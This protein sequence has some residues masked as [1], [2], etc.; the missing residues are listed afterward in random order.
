[1]GFLLGKRA[2][3][4][5]WPRYRSILPKTLKYLMGS[6]PEHQR[7]ACTTANSL[8]AGE[9]DEFNR[10]LEESMVSSK[11]GN[12]RES[13]PHGCWNRCALCW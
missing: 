12:L 8:K 3:V 7:Q 5:I 4:L 9:V 6:D 1:M 13:V 2:E 10:S 11:E